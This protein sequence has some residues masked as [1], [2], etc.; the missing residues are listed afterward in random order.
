MSAVGYSMDSSISA[1]DYWGMPICAVGYSA[2]FESL[3]S[4]LR[5][6]LGEN[7][8]LDKLYRLQRRM[9]IGT[10]GYSAN[11]ESPQ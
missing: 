4:P 1:V 6:F 10:G 3:S 2:N 8:T 7:Y 11:F 9:L 5:E